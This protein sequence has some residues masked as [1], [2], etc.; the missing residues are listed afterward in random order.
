[1]YLLFPA[2]DKLEEPLVLDEV[3]LQVADVLEH[4]QGPCQGSLPWEN[5]TVLVKGYFPEVENDSILNEDKNKARFY[6]TDIRNGM[7]IEIRVDGDVD[8]VFQF[9]SG[10]MKKDRLYIRGMTESII[11]NQGSE[12]T[13]GVI[14]VLSDVSDLAINL[15]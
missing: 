7:F 11:A 2:C 6:L 8:A 4:C 13:K 9:L 10:I 15:E 5:N 12:C 14:V 3:Y 1:V